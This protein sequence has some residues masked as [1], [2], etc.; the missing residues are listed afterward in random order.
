V[1]EKDQ[2]RS[3]H[4]SGATGLGGL[5]SPNPKMILPL[6]FPCAAC[7]TAVFASFSG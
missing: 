1:T 6:R 4:Q 2:A 5:H 3:D 7:V